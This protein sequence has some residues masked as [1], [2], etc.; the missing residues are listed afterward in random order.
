M[1]DF[2]IKMKIQFHEK[3]ENPI[4][5]FSIK[6]TK[7]LE[8][9]GTNTII[10]QVDTGIVQKGQIVQ[11]SFTQRMILQGGQNLLQLGC[12]GYEGDNLAVYHRLY[13]ICCMNIIS[14]KTTV[15]Y[16]DLDSTVELDNVTNNR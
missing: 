15:G 5:A 11:I 3:I 2:T 1:S 12:T 16:C 6:N 9:T 13:D 14:D 8:L 4:F 10:E 7:G